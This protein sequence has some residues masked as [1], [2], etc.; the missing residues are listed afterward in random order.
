MPNQSFTDDQLIKLCVQGN[1]KAQ[2]YLYDKYA[3]K[4]FG[5]CRRY[6]SVDADAEEAVYS[7]FYKIFSNISQFRAE[8][9]F[10]AWM[11]R[12]I[13][14]EC[15]LFLR[16]KKTKKYIDTVELQQNGS[17]LKTSAYHADDSIRES[18][19]LKLLEGLPAGYRTVFN[20]YA[21]EG[22][23]HSEI[24]TM[25]NISINTSKSQL[26]KARKMLQQMITNLEK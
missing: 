23:K 13:V 26:L 6:L 14:N 9:D 1:R 22:Y 17:L 3:A 5:L 8:G 11:R 16:S 24:A 10:E 20:L 4:M 19:I 21:I 18:D 7:G 15:L 12:I 25:L 2:R